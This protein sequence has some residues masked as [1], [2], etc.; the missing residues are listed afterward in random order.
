MSSEPKYSHL[1]EAQ[2]LLSSYAGAL[3]SGPYAPAVDVSDGCQLFVYNSSTRPVAFFANNRAEGNCTSIIQ[4]TAFTVRAWSVSILDLTKPTV[5]YNSHTLSAATI[6]AADRYQ[7]RL[8]RPLSSWSPTSADVFQWRDTSAPWPSADVLTQPAPAEQLN[9][10]QY[11]SQYLW[12]VT[13]FT[14]RSVSDT[15]TLG[16]SA[17][18]DRFQAF[19]DGSDAL[20]TGGV[21]RA[22]TNFSLSTP[23]L[24]A[25]LHTLRVRCALIGLDNV[26]QGQ[27]FHDTKGLLG[28]VLVN[29]VDATSNGWQHVVGLHGEQLRVFDGG[30]AEWTPYN[31]TDMQRPGGVWLR[32]TMPAPAVVGDPATATWQLDMSAMQRG[33]VWVNGFN[34]GNYWNIRATSGCGACKYEGGYDPESCRTDC[35]QPSQRKYHVPRD[36]LRVQSAQ[37]NEVVLYEEQG[38]DP[39]HISVQQRT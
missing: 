10:T 36:V 37:S 24:L 32:F 12:Y 34:V 1:A 33:L 17:V 21:V 25:G 8:A 19:V 4:G 14:T 29:G 22:L 30:R 5:V 3:L 26:D 6:A 15:V 11:R 2:A 31:G 13:N 7:Q 39:L 27:S 18:A 35:G 28:S 38:G 20:A 16:L 23:G 9:A